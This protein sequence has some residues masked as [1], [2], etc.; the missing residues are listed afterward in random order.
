MKEKIARVLCWLVYKQPVKP[1]KGL[2]KGDKTY[3]I[4]TSERKYPVPCNSCN[5]IL[6][7]ERI[8][9]ESLEEG[10]LIFFEINPETREEKMFQKYHLPNCPAVRPVM[11]YKQGLF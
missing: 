6:Q 8:S 1:M 7:D 4:E 2:K 11:N 10:G 9:F 5:M 3:I